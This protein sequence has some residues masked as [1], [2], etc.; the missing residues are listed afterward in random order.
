MTK[1]QKHKIDDIKGIARL[2]MVAF[3]DFENIPDHKSRNTAIEICRDRLV[4]MMIVSDYVMI[5]E[6]LSEIMCRHFFDSDKSSIELWKTRRFKTFNYYV[7]EEMPL[8]RKLALAKFIRRIPP[9][10]EETIRL[11]NQLRNAVA[12]SF[13][14]M[15]KRDFKRT[16]RVTYKGRDVFTLAGA[17]EL[18]RDVTRA[19]AFLWPLAYKLRSP[20]N[21]KKVTPSPTPVVMTS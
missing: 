6:L 17:T 16:K 12:H 18:H 9:K 15:N 2:G 20:R 4:R 3:W 10:I 8:M 11:T 21:R 7:L 13:F 1:R 5:D 14:P 19:T